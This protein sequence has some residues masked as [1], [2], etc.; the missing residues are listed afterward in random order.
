MSRRP[1]AVLAVDGGNSKADL[2]LV[3]RDGSLLALATGPTISHQQVPM[4]VAVE[5]LRA[6]RDEAARMAGAANHAAEIGTFC[7]AGADFPADIRDLHR[8]FAASGLAQRV[9]VRN[10]AFAA[11]RAGAPRGWGVVVVC[12]SGVNAVGVA[13]DG[14]MARLAGI[15][16]YSGD[17]GGGY[18]V[19]KEALGQAVR[20]RDGRG[21]DTALAHRVPEH[22]G[23]RRPIDVVRAIYDGRI[24]D[25]RIE[26][27]T[28]ITFDAATA[29]DPVARAIIDRLAD[30]LATM[31]IAIT[32]RLRLVRQPIDVV[33]T[34]GVF[35]ATDAAFL[36]RL[37][38]RVVDAVPGAVVR[39]L[40][41][42]PVLG[43]ALIGL[44]HLGIPPAGAA[45]RRLRRA[46]EE[47][48]ATG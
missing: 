34:G 44:D 40:R 33:L 35:R 6:L 36:A 12:G 46:F 4:D 30:E 18:G 16:D 32:R 41:E 26:E 19:G 43:A 14:R 24:P 23:M 10:D 45:E 17:W 48:R 25:R 31:A 42:R 39:R 47:R 21:P 9:V 22:F 2:V 38:Q 5:R 7:V 11:L 20:A 3:A 37:D 1:P 29:G 27:L 15:G 8:A 28:P 13:P